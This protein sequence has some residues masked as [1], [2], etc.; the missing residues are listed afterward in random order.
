MPVEKALPP[1]LPRLLA[2]LALL[3]GSSCTQHGAEPEIPEDQG[4]VSEVETQ[5]EEP[6]RAEVSSIPRR[7]DD[8][9][10]DE[11]RA[12]KAN[13]GLDR[14]TLRVMTDDGLRE[15]PLQETTF[16]TS[17][18]ATVAETEVTQVFAN[19]FKEPI[20]ALYTFPLHER[21]AVD[22]YRIEIG[23]RSIHGELKKRAEAKREYQR[24][25]KEGRSAALLEQERTN[26]F[27]Q[28]I[29]NIMPGESIAVRMHVVQPLAQEDGR[30]ELVLPT[31]VGPRYVGG[32]ALGGRPS[33]HGEAPDTDRV[34]DG[35]RIS[36]P[37][38]APGSVACSP[39]A[40]SVDVETGFGAPQVRSKHHAVDVTTANDVATIEL[41]HGIAVPNRDFVLSWDIERDSPHASFLVQADPSGGDGGYFTLTI[42]PPDSLR[43]ESAVPR[44]L[45][46]V[47][48]NSGSM[49]GQPMEVAKQTVRTAV[50]NLNPDDT[51]QIMRFSERASAMSKRPLPNTAANRRRGVEYIDGMQGMGGTEMLEG[52]RAALAAPR[53]AGRLPIVMF[54]TDGYIGSETDIFR[55]VANTIAGNR[56][57]SVGVGSA[58]NRML[59]DGL[60]L[61]GRGSAAYIGLADDPVDAV[62]AFYDK[63][64]FPAL[65]DVEFDWGGLDVHDV[66]P[67]RIPDLFVGQP[68][69][70][71]GRYSG[72]PKGN[73]DVKGR[74]GSKDVSLPITVD[75]AKAR[76]TDGRGLA[77]MWARTKIEELLRGP[78]VYLLEQSKVEARRAESTALALKHS[79]LTE[80]TAFVAVDTTKRANPDGT[81]RTEV[82][83]V[84]EVWGMLTGTEV[85]EAYGVG[86]LGLVG[87]GRGGGGTGEGTIGLGNV[88]LVGKGGGGGSSAG[89][90]RGSGGGFG[91][92]GARVPRVRQAKA[93]V[94][95]S[96]DKGLLRRVVR[97]HIN[98]VRAC[99]T[100]AL[101]A[102]PNAKGR[103]TVRFTF[104]AT[105]TVVSAKIHG[106]TM[107]AEA[108]KV[109]KCVAKAVKTWTFPP[110]PA[111]GPVTVTYPFVLSPG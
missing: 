51:F 38:L 104:D 37:R 18:L 25:K 66:V 49:H 46:F 85:G 41:T 36:P 68:V 86:G 95:G 94:T 32:A 99:Y 35:S 26:V 54:L 64:A 28:S 69:V 83:E 17:V 16:E 63:V 27:T 2:T 105:G 48:D 89:Y 106:N 102:D 30:Y 77:S 8:P 92:R 73:I 88:G 11:P 111:S 50:E 13:E 34:P 40:I 20:E 10:V 107:S 96:I 5:Q 79:V 21:A 70:V 57:F 42:E 87:T 52:I 76:T 43:P 7:C 1:V 93:K 23:D 56:I 84:E 61:A 110:A 24:A 4:E 72:K 44:D 3:A 108:E 53:G 19:P 12:I 15:I 109:G 71:Y 60:A 78:E 91:G 82:V 31:V 39:V 9:L 14:A 103:V 29:A 100:K 62:D 59:L 47:V 75:F 81:V 58:P 67:T 90:G 97:S 33:G 80:H 101:A 98:E 22:E 74:L 65:S 55:E 45:V 6:E